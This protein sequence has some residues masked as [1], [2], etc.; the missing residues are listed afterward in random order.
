MAGHRRLRHLGADQRG[1]RPRG[2][3]GPVVGIG[4]PGVGLVPGQPSRRHRPLLFAG[5][6]TGFTVLAQIAARHL[7]HFEAVLERRLGVPVRVAALRPQGRGQCV[8][9][10]TTARGLCGELGRDI[11]RGQLDRRPR[12]SRGGEPADAGVVHGPLDGVRRR[13][14]RGYLRV[15]GDALTR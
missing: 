7:A 12:N 2:G 11:D 6:G 10:D 8:D 9:C 14:E 15:Q 4:V 3:G 5:A 1:A 13:G